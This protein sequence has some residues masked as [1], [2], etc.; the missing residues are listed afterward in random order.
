[1]DFGYDKYQYNVLEV[2]ET[3]YEK[4]IDKDFIKN[5][6]GGAG[7]DVFNLTQTK[8]YYFLSSGGYCF[9]GLKVAVN[10]LRPMPPAPAPMSTSTTT[11]TTFSSS[12][13]LPLVLLLI[14][15]KY[16]ERT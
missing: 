10:V 3:S 15:F 14:D 2:T 6:T 1:M 9:Q 7:R 13:L 5:I 11:T 12:L 8:T 4:C 16:K